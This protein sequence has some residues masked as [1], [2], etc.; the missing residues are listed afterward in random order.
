MELYKPIDCNLYD[1]Y[2]RYIIEKRKVLI[3]DI[4]DSNKKTVGLIKDIYTNNGMEYISLV[5]GE[6]KRLDQ[7]TIELF[8]EVTD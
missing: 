5:N 8:M 6:D 3:T 1:V 4:L 2:I 7:I